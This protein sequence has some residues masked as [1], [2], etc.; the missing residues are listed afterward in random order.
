MG[1][2]KIETMH[3]AFGYNSLDD[4]CKQ[5]SYRTLDKSFRIRMKLRYGKRGAFSKSEI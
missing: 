5:G 2:T 4:T 1:Q 3:V